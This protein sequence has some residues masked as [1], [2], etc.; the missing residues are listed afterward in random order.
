MKKVNDELVETEVHDFWLAVT[1]YDT[2]WKGSNHAQ[3]ETHWND[4]TKDGKTL[5]NTVWQDR[6]V[7]VLDG[8]E[9][10]RFVLLGG[11][12]RSWKSLSVT[13]G[14]L[15]DAN[16]HHAINARDRI[17]GYETVGNPSMLVKGE[18]RVEYFCMEK[19]VELRPVIGTRG[20]D[21]KA[22]LKLADAFRLNGVL[23]GDYI[24]AAPWT[25]ELVP[26]NVPAP[27]LTNASSATP[28]RVLLPRHDEDGG[29]KEEPATYEGYARRALPELVAHVL[30]QR[31]GVMQRISY[32]E[33]ARRI[34]KRNYKGEAWARGMGGVLNIITGWID[35]LQP[36][37]NDEIPYLTSVVVEKTADGKDGLPGVGVSAKFPGYAS[38]TSERKEAVISVE[39]EKILNFGMRWN[40]VLGQLGMDP[41]E[42]VV[43]GSGDLL[44]GTG[45]GGWGGGESEAHKALKKYVAEHPELFGVSLTAKVTEEYPLHSRDVLDVFFET[46]G[47]WVGIEVKSRVSDGDMLDYRRGVYQVVKYRSL[48]EAQAKAEQPG[49]PISVKVFLVLE[50][51]MPAI[52]ET[53]PSTL[54]VK[55]FEGVDPAS[56]C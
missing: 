4:Y 34:D 30:A 45:H 14:K 15:A 48:L 44:T 47:E 7:S 24:G 51:F 50:R 2:W 55:I 8:D 5:V 13:H 38:F 31:D 12:R 19:A 35:D 54:D 37:W 20:D 53:L 41:V 28:P 9:V 33:L 17:V 18:R 26:L 39:Y 42:P 10:R 16:L 21:L 40:E 1:G 6:I 32:Q 46:E 29:P 11:K 27:H 22:R 52:F 43:G 25:F 36:A 56:D 3:R 49:K 23:D